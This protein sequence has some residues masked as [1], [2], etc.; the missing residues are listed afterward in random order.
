VIGF[1]LLYEFG[2]TAS[3]Q[4]TQSGITFGSASAI[5]LRSAFQEM[6]LYVLAVRFVLFL[7]IGA[8]HFPLGR[9]LTISVL[10][11]ALPLALACE[12]ICGFVFFQDKRDVLY[13]FWWSLQ[14]R[15]STAARILQSFRQT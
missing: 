6:Q 5:G 1:C 2:E 4:Y 11:S 8:S 12:S 7:L 3:F 14:T 10:T 9:R 15:T 13:R